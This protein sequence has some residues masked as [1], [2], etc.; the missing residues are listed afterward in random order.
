[1]TDDWILELPPR[2][3]RGV[4]GLGLFETAS[5]DTRY[6]LD[7]K[8]ELQLGQDVNM[9]G[10]GTLRSEAIIR[11]YG[12]DFLFELQVLHRAGEGSTVRVNFAPLFAWKR[13][14][15]GILEQ[16]TF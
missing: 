7:E 8:W 12:A 15:L 6:R 13:R 11:R 4:D 1:P 9:I 16:R 5:F 2:R 3:G 14:P 10:S